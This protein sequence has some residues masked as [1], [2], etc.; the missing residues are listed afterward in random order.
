[1]AFEVPL[2]A[3]RVDDHLN[4]FSTIV[5]APVMTLQWILGGSNKDEDAPDEHH[6]ELQALD[7]T[8][9]QE[10]GNN[11]NL[12]T[13]KRSYTK[14]SSGLKKAAPS[15]IGSEISDIGE[16]R[17]SLDTMC[18]E[19]DSSSS[20]FVPGSFKSK[21]SLSWSD[22]LGKE[23]VDD[24]VSSDQS[25]FAMLGSEKRAPPWS[26]TRVVETRSEGKGKSLPGRQAGR[27]AGRDLDI[28]YFWLTVKAFLSVCPPSVSSCVRIVDK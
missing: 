15:L 23:L 27:Q 9:S 4:I 8:T 17:E 1:M 7:G 5:R 3:D 21:K 2:E 10:T 16:V 18:L 22:E 14:R 28:Y 11:N 13:M 6:E 25:L 19:H 26:T 20:R 24:K 12:P